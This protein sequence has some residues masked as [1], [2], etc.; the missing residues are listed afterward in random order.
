MGNKL[1]LELLCSQGKWVPQVSILRPGISR[2]QTTR[3]Q[4]RSFSNR[5]PLKQSFLSL[6]PLDYPQHCHPT[7]LNA[8]KVRKDLR[9]FW[10]SRS[11]QFAPK[12]ITS[13]WP[14]TGSQST[15]GRVECGQTPM[16]LRA[17][18]LTFSVGGGILFAAL[19]AE[20]PN[21]LNAIPLPIIAVVFWPVSICE[22]LV[23]L[24]PNIGSPSHPIHEGT[25][26]NVVAAVVGYALSWMFWSGLVLTI[27]TPRRQ[28]KT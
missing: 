19:I 18:L 1:G 11:L 25:P 12:M 7:T 20:F 4:K 21:A 26:L 16:S 9:L 27:I 28:R 14:T 10:R 2:T 17:K 24:G 13:P 5:R 3:L 6:R 8:V 23:P 22:Y 15:F